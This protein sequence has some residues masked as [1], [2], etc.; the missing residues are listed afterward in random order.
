MYAFANIAHIVVTLDVSHELISLLNEC[1]FRNKPLISVIK[2]VT[3]LL[4]GTGV[5]R[6]GVCPVGINF[7]ELDEIP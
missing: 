2:V 4:K 6:A 5:V 3:I 7:D 1:T